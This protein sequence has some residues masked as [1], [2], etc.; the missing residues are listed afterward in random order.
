M[1]ALIQ[2]QNLTR[3]PARPSRRSAPQSSRQSQPRAGHLRAVP[4]PTPSGTEQFRQWVLGLDRAVVGVAA[5]CAVIALGFVSLGMI[6][7]QARASA[8][9][10]AV[11][12]ASVAPAGLGEA[13]LLV[14]SGD[15]MWDLASAVAGPGE[16][17]RPVMD[18]LT[19]RNGSS[20]LWAGQRLVIPAEFVDT[21]LA[22]GGPAT[23]TTN[24]G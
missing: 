16:D 3:T 11:A 9:P 22:L 20:A 1:V 15:T 13:T 5:I 18:A 4:E 23:V 19:A 7:G 24:A 12:P 14:T 8:A 21:V 2:P 10:A 6:Q 17:P